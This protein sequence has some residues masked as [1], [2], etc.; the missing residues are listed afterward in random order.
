MMR[1]D[2]Q[3]RQREITM[4]DAATRGRKKKGEGP[5][6]INFLDADGKDFNRVPAAVKNVQVADKK[7]VKKSFALSEITPATIYQLAA[8]ELKR[9]LNSGISADFDE[10][11]N[12]VISLAEN[13]FADIKSGKL[14]Q[15]AESKP[16][17][18]RT[19]DTG[20]WVDVVARMSKIMN[21]SKP[22]NARSKSEIESL[23]VA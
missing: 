2:E 4:A 14:F 12:N 16:G 1:A 5:F 8:S 3:H 9:K 15:R 13:I 17:A 19:F 18:G 6:V 10:K 22:K 11:S 21:T 20:M 23:K 7:G